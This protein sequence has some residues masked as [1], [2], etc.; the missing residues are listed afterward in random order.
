MTKNEIKC[1]MC[2]GQ[3]EEA[4][5][6]V[7]TSTVQG[8]EIIITGL[9]G[10]RC[11]GCGEQY[12]DAESSK[13]AIETA[14]KFRKPAIIFKRKVTVSGGRRVIGIP[15]EIDRALGKKDNVDL[16]LEGDKI[17]AQVY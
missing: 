1:V 4:K 8:R 12:V 11:P 7:I 15:E 17:V 13:K 3:T 16:W 9:T 6:I 14:N 2:A 10:T 5:D